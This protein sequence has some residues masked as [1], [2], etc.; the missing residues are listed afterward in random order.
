MIF[1]VINQLLTYVFTWMSNV[2]K[3]QLKDPKENSSHSII[4][5]Y[6]FQTLNHQEFQVGITNTLWLL[7]VIVSQC[8][9]DNLNQMDINHGLWRFIHLSLF[10]ATFMIQLMNDL[11][12]LMQG[13]EWCVTIY[14][15]L[16]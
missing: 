10:A 13:Y 12:L 9:Y 15:I 6:I 16:Y 4:S 14:F 1:L 2:R 11:L 8:C 5:D 3:T 7:T